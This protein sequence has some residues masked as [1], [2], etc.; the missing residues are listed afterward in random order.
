[1]NLH[2]CSLQARASSVSLEMTLV[3]YLVHVRVLLV[4]P[5]PQVLS[6]TDQERQAEN[7]GGP[8][9]IKSFRRWSPTMIQDYPGGP[10]KI[11]KI[12]PHWKS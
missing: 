8:E 5:P 4:S 3:Q 1:M 9:N 6:Q 12:F 10:E 7:S 11:M 2:L